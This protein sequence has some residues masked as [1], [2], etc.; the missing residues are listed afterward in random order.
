MKKEKQ[1]MY[2]EKEELKEYEKEYIEESEYGAKAVGSCFFPQ[3]A[4]S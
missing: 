4:G 1:E 3:T 2:E